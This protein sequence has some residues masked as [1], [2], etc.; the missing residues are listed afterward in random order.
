[1]DKLDINKL[2]KG[3]SKNIKIG[4]LTQEV[5]DSL[6]L[7]LKPQNINVWS[8]R[9]NEHCEK[10]KLEYSS[11]AAYNEAVSSIPLIIK[12]PDYIGLH[13][14]SGNIQYIKRLND[15]S[16]VGIKVIKGKDGGLLFRTIFPITEDK[17]QHSVRSGKFIKYK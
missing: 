1:M 8:T 3:T 15:I 11:P 12:E 9:I 10:H 2:N 6:G 7:D 13:S 4:E 17:L 14:K 5:I 16:L